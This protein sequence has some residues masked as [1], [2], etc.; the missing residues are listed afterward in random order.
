[1]GVSGCE[2]DL[3]IAPDIHLAER[4]FDALRSRTGSADGICRAS[5]GEGEAIAHA[6]VHKEAEALGLAI[7][8]DAALNLYVTLR[9]VERGSSIIIGSH[10]DS[11]PRGGNFDGAA[12]V[13]MGL[14]VQAGFVRAKTRPKRDII[15]MAIRAEES[16]WF[17]AS[18]IGSRAALGQLRAEELNS[19]IRSDNGRTL[20]DHIAAAG[21]D[22]D[23]LRTGKA[24]LDPK[25]ISAFIE[26][27]IEQGPDL[28]DKKLPVGIVT[29]IRGSSRYRAARCVGSY[30]HSGATPRH[31]RRDAVASCAA[32]LVRVNALWA[33]FEVR[34]ED[35]TVTVGQMMTDEAEHAFSKVSGLVSFSLDMRSQS[36]AILEDFH[37]GLM[38]IALDVMREQGVTFDWGPVSGSQAA[39]MDQRIVRALSAAASAVGSEAPAMP[40]GAGHDAA[41]FANLGIPTGM[42]FI[43]NQNGSHNPDE[44][45]NIADF[46]VGADILLRF[47]LE[48][49]EKQA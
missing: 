33:E 37:S 32:L 14:A 22:V 34:G 43:R 23:T 38:A 10:L 27:H 24:L 41:V 30:A 8:R 16:T 26:P 17:N 11:V 6:L 4:L 2:S 3:L 42:L 25:S 39:I 47:C 45:M 1:M 13:L 46:T 44:A 31:L 49:P 5:Y 48:W 40:C 18:Y 7:T 36:K 12:G 29:G 9:G 19:V 21:G 35:L 20:G 28:S 15:V